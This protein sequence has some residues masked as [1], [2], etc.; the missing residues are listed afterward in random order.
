MGTDRVSLT[1]AAVARQ[2]PG[3]DLLLVQEVRSSILQ[4]NLPGG[5]LE[6]GEDMSHGLRREIA[7]ETGLSATFV[8][9]MA[10]L[11]EAIEPDSTRSLAVIFE[12]A[13]SGK[14]RRQSGDASVQRV[15]YHPLASLEEMLAATIPPTRDPLLAYMR[16]EERPG[17]HWAYRRDPNGEFS[18]LS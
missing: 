12:A 11:V 3:G 5:K 6:A 7:E 2:S 18:Q 17:K 16:G 14:L 13:L 8:G 9:R 10:Y 15:A 1:V 4:W